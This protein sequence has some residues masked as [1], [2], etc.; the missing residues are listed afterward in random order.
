MKTKKSFLNIAFGAH[1]ALAIVSLLPGFL[2]IYKA[3]FGYSEW[4]SFVTAMLSLFVLLP[5]VVIIKPMVIVLS[6]LSLLLHDVRLIILTSLL[7]TPS[8]NVR[9]SAK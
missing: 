7:S 8:R 1:M 9:F 3:A 4:L 5:L 6:L 2:D